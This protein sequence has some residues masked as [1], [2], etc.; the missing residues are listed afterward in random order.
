MGELLLAVMPPLSVRNPAL[1]SISSR[2]ASLQSTLDRFPIEGPYGWCVADKYPQPARSRIAAWQEVVVEL[3]RRLAWF[4]Y[5][6]N[7]KLELAK[8]PLKRELTRVLEEMQQLMH[9]NS[10]LETERDEARGKLVPLESE[11][12]QLEQSLSAELTAHIETRSE[13]S[14]LKKRYHADLAQWEDQLSAER[15]ARNAALE[16][17]EAEIADLQQRRKRAEELLNEQQRSL[18]SK[19]KQMIETQ[20][21]L[22][23]S[24]LKVDSA[25]HRA[26]QLERKL[27]Y[28]DQAMK[29]E[30]ARVAKQ[31]EEQAQML[32]QA[33]QLEIDTLNGIR[34]QEKDRHDAQVDELKACMATQ[35]QAHV[36]E[37]SKLRSDL[38][39][40]K[41]E[42][43]E[44]EQQIAEEL[45]QQMKGL[46][47]KLAA[48]VEALRAEKLAHS[49]DLA[50]LEAQLHTLQQENSELLNDKQKELNILLAKLQKEEESSA[51][52][53][54]KIAGI[55]EDHWN[56]VSSSRT[57]GPHTS[58]KAPYNSP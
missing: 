49:S 53:R 51:R 12:S 50:K 22:T 33:H 37:L 34:Q 8:E 15:R 24:E 36:K 48:Q 7:D 55:E 17:H 29:Q 23:A 46:V 14:A 47:A 11:V 54:T 26:D 39:A 58:D 4:E 35:A 28:A 2:A 41:A 56:Y 19:S 9:W 1:P 18:E 20:T 13:L 30:K 25:E 45:R 40:R 38:E 6:A 16:R 57:A 3:Q 31:L 43:V 52:L 32:R 44:S 27:E 10:L 21:R 5:E 42:A